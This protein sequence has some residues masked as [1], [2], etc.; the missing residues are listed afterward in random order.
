[1]RLRCVRVW[2]AGWVRMAEFHF[3]R[4][5]WL[6]LLPAV[7]FVAWRILSGRGAGGGW[8]KVVDSALQPYVLAAPAAL[9]ERR[10]PT[11]LGLASAVLIT[12]ALAGPAWDRLP[13][14]AYRSDEALVVAM[15]LS[16]SM[17]AGDLEPSRLARAKIKL[18]SLL[19]R[20]PNGQTALVVFSAHAFTVTPLT[21]DTATVAALVGALQ[22]D[23]MPS[24]GSYPEAGLTKAATLLTQAG[25]TAGQILLVSDADVSP[26]SLDAA[27]DL[28]RRGYTTHVLAVGTVDGAP[29]PRLEGGFMTDGSGQ[30][31]VPQLHPDQLRRLAR[32]G[33]G[34]FAQ[35]TP[36]DRD[37]DTLFPSETVGALQSSEDGEQL[38]ADIWRDQGIWLALLLLPI[39]ALGFRRGWIYLLVAAVTLPAPEAQALSWRDLWQRPDQQGLEAF[40]ADEPSRA[41]RLF[42]DPQWR[43]AASYRA[44]NFATSAESLTGID[45]PEAHYNRGNALA[46]SGELTAAIEAYD[47]ALSLD[48][49]H[50]DALYNRD[51]V[52]ELLEQQQ[53]QEQEQQQSQANDSG[54]QQSRAS[55]EEGQQSDDSESDQGDQSQDQ[56]AATGEQRQQDPP[57]SSDSDPGQDQRQAGSEPEETEAEAGERQMQ[58]ATLPED[59]EEWASEQAADQWLR[60]IPQDPGGLL[61][62]KFL[63]QYQRLG[64][65]QEGNYVWP[66]DEAEPW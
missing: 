38:E 7:A 19:E 62:R 43:A 55:T 5:A 20:R 16:R 17:D 18:L 11:V 31:V 28:R 14:P 3:L 4:P 10:L 37:L 41:A 2:P 8:Q 66:G 46:K 45:S 51:L 53:E 13:V 9:R 27:R 23:I 15:D 54:Q 32:T 24:Q 36:D 56:S 49:E 47:R 12:L 35:L 40:Q 60:R 63:Y 25:M 21:T 33:G 26:Q 57:T 39:I 1:M 44:G 22:T 29:I 65:D 34:R 6:L 61:R 52:R 48:P 30:V 64:V 59:V 50:E 58:A 42:E